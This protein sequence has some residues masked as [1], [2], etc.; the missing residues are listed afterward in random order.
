MPIMITIMN[1]LIT[2]YIHHICVVAVFG[3][4]YFHAIKLTDW[5]LAQVIKMPIMITIM[6]TL[7]TVIRL[8]PFPSYQ[9]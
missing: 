3:K 4:T 9:N 1:T 6:N 8:G 5:A 2:V 7:I